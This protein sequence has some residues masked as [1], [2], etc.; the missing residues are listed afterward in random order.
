MNN[1]ANLSKQQEVNLLMCGFSHHT[2]PFQSDSTHGVKGYLFRLQTEGRAS[3]LLN[4]VMHPLEAGDLILYPPGTPYRLDISAYPMLGREPLVSSGDYYAACEGS[5]LDNWWKRRLRPLLVRI[6][7]SEQLL[8]LW[9]MLV[10]E[11]RRLDDENKELT[12]YLARSL[13]LSFDRF[14]DA[15]AGKQG[16]PFIAARIKSFIEEHATASFRLDELSSHVGLSVSRI[17]HLFKACYGKTIIEYMHEV[18]L[19]MAEERIRYSTLTLE[20]IAESCGFSSY[21]YFFRV[22]RNK[23]GISPAEFRSAAH[24]SEPSLQI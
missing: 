13:C 5:W 19:S 11:K 23:Y 2:E 4:G 18:R 21:S 14:I 7:M 10:L 15:Q 1:S 22:F 6:E 16:K 8:S 17:S 12:E 20:Q 9:R 24:A 3:V